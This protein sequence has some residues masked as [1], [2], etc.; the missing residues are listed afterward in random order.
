MSPWN[1]CK[2]LEALSG[3]TGKDDVSDSDFPMGSE[4]ACGTLCA[5]FA[6]FAVNA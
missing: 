4:E 5:T 1:T 2:G 6:V 3:F